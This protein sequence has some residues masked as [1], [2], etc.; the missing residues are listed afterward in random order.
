VGQQ[1]IKSIALIIKYIRAF[2]FLVAGT[3]LAQFSFCPERYYCIE[4][5][6]GLL[7][8]KAQTVNI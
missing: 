4:G 6:V 7:I 8:N 1:I 3:W 2:Y 5:L